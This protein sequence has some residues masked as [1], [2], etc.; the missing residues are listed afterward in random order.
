[1]KLVVYRR[2]HFNPRQELKVIILPLVLDEDKKYLNCCFLEYQ[3]SHFQIFFCAACTADRENVKLE[4]A[5]LTICRS[6]QHQP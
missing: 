2:C 6:Q 3:Q 4:D 1:M 5:P